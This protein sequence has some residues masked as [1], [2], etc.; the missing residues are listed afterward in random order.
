VIHPAQLKVELAGCG[1]RI[2]PSLS[3]DPSL[4]PAN[5]ARRPVDLVLPERVRVT[6][7]VEEPSPFVLCAE[8][9]G[10]VLVRHDPSGAETLR[11]AVRVTPPPRFLTRRTRRGTA[12]ERVA[13]AHGS[14]LVVHPASACGFSVRGAPCRFCVEGARVAADREAA[15]V[16]DVLEVVRAAFE[17]GASEDVYFNTGFY[18]GEDGGIG[19]LAPYIE[20]VRRH[21]DT[22]IAVQVHPPR[23][24]AWIDRTYA[25]GVDALSYNL[26][27]FDAA[28]LERHCIGRARYIGRERYLEALGH[29][30]RIFPSGTVWTDL[31]I[32]L[33]PPA[34][35]RA[36][37][38][39]LAAA[40][41][42][43]V[44][45]LVHDGSPAPPLAEL[46]PVL[47]HLY[48][49]VKEHGINM[50]WVRDLGL[51]I[52][53][54]E[55]RWFAGDGARLAVAVQAL[56]RSRLGGLAARGLSR[57]RRRLRV[58]RIQESFDSSHL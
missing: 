58:R 18:D 1:V 46:A 16:E 39:A 41:I 57:F 27:I 56:T 44:V 32:G 30:A 50:G 25:M 3:A 26:E 5:G 48:R 12:M 31:V 55:A 15:A 47:A 52:T 11:V 51:G 53:P 36:G 10:H 35:T 21:F 6:A 33:E 20:A 45:S 14:H 8:G 9:D 29:A 22:L 43:P 23:T 4:F 34:S 24:S 42:V 13:T 17:E 38:E 19:F 37:I 49:A 28:T 7:P 54:L 2:D 40:G